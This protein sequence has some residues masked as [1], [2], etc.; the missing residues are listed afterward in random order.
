MIQT[1]VVQKYQKEIFLNNFSKYFLRE[2]C[3]SEILCWYVISYQIIS[4]Q[5][6]RSVVSDSL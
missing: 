2:L 1:C 3:H 5:I 4:V 6:S